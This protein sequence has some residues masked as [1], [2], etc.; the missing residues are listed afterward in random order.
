MLAGI[1]RK[2]GA[3]QINRMTPSKNQ[4]ERLSEEDVPFGSHYFPLNRAL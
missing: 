4:R 3:A 2:E 1:Y